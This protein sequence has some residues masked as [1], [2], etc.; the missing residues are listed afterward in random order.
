MY[1][2]PE[3]AGPSRKKKNPRYDA[4]GNF[5]PPED[6]SSGWDDYEIR[7]ALR[8]LTSAAKIRKNPALLRAVQR[9]AKKQVAAA[10]ATAASL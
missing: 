8:T 9:E 5:I 1:D 3:V 6:R 4:K 2:G 7:D 10:K